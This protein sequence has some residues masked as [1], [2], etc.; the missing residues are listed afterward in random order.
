MLELWNGKGA[1][2]FTLPKFQ[3]RGR[4][5]TNYL[6]WCEWQ[7]LHLDHSRELICE[8]ETGLQS[9]ALGQV[10][11]CLVGG[12][13]FWHL[14]RDVDSY[15]HV[16]RWHRT[17]LVK[18]QIQI[19]MQ[20]AKFQSIIP[21][22][23]AHLGQPQKRG[24]CHD[25]VHHGRWRALHWVPQAIYSSHL[26]SCCTQQALLACVAIAMELDRMSLLC[27]WVW[28]G[29]VGMGGK[30]MR[31]PWPPH[32]C[33]AHGAPPP[34]TASHRAPATNSNLIWVYSKFHTSSK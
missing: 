2:T 4:D 8:P 28:T 24:P 15:A 5:D 20:N 19:Q 6:C 25:G 18:I 14:A 10:L 30:S 9:R 11:L 21:W 29:W 23:A 22:E 31:L 7:T 32:S 27:P 1:W 12:G 33:L 3:R 16:Q 13:P 17:K 26:F 34:Q